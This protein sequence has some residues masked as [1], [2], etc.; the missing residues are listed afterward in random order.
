MVEDVL[1]EGGK[2]CAEGKYKEGIEVFEKGLRQYPSSI[3]IQYDMA[4]AFGKLGDFKTSMHWL[5]NILTIAPDNA[6]Y[7]SERAVLLYHMGNM[8]G[9][10][11]ELDRAAIIEPE[12][13]FRY[14]SRAW[15]KAKAGDIDGAIADYDK[16]VALDPEDA[17]ALNNKGMLEEQLGY[18]FKSKRSFK[19]SDD[20][21][22]YDPEKR[23]ASISQ[24]AKTVEVDEPEEAPKTFATAT[25]Q[26]FSG[27]LSSKKVRNEFISFLK[28]KL[29]L[30]KGQ[31]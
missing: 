13:P 18:T 14:S 9:A 1:A 12:N 29:G 24:S 2:L 23:E 20:L 10:I 31:T 27:L 5:N 28:I 19:Q 8:E 26:V 25:K 6:R 17:I 15:I 11:K 4:R 21:V 3:L 7:I 16:A 30:T 22:G